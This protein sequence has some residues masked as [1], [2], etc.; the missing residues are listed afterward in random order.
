[1]LVKVSIEGAPIR[2]DISQ[3]LG[4][5][6]GQ[7]E[8]MTF[9]L[10]DPAVTTADVWIV[11]E[12]PPQYDLTCLAQRTVFVAAESMWGPGREAESTSRQIYLSQFDS[13]H[14][15]Q[16][17]YWPN[18]EFATPFLPWMINANHGDSIF[19]PHNRDVLFF[20]TLS[21]LPK[22]RLL[23][24]ICS[25]KTY[26]EGHRL[27][28]RFVEALANELGDSL[29]WFGN[30]HNSISEKWEA[31]AP[32]KFHLV[33]ENQA[34]YGIITEKL[35]DSFLGLAHPFYYGAPDAGQHF[36]PDSFTPINIRDFTGSVETIRSTIAREAKF[37]QP[38][39]LLAK[40]V[41]LRDW[42]LFRRLGLVAAAESR[43]PGRDGVT[44]LTHPSRRRDAWRRTV[45]RVRSSK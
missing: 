11:V 6:Q 1:M 21:S 15:F 41:V 2:A 10:N 28:L 35:I 37:P 4:N 17:L 26:T 45:E 13:I 34:A 8:G 20:E 43:R 12:A 39:T 44:T 32:Y 22:P 24:V 36:P 30:G 38:S 19:S 23:S 16:D 40:D 18:V 25:T 27:R 5:K 14:T 7:L 42:N 29:D 31:I 9:A 33:I 3:Y